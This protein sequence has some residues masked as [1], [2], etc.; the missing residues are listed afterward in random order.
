M[1]LQMIRDLNVTTTAPATTTTT[2]GA[3]IATAATATVSP[4]GFWLL[5]QFSASSAQ[6]MLIQPRTINSQA[7]THSDVHTL[8]LLLLMKITTAATTV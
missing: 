3:R 8:L 1:I 6:A 5:L 4:P 7:H 2:L